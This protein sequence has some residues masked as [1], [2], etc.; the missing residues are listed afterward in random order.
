MPVIT[1][2]EVLIVLG[3]L[4]WTIHSFLKVAGGP[5]GAKAFDNYIANFFTSIL[6]I[7]VALLGNVEN[8]LLP[9]VQAF[10][11]SV[12]TLGP[13]MNATMKAPAAAL[14]DAILSTAAHSLEGKTNIKP[15]DWNAIAGDAMA[16]AVGFGLG[17]FATSAAF[18]AAFPEKL[19]T[20]NSLGPMLATLSGFEEVSRAAIRPVLINGIAVP[21]GYDS[22]SK[23]R[24]HLPALGATLALWARRKITNAE[25]DTLLAYNGMSPDWVAALQAGAYRPLQP[26]MLVNLLRD[27]PIDRATL[28]AMLEDAALSPA[29]VQLLA[30]KIIYNSDANVR[31]SLL[32]AL[33]T[34]YG[35]GVTSD[36]ELNDA[37]TQFNFSSEAKQYVTAHVLILRREVLAA[38]AEKT[39]VPLVANGNVSADE[40]LQQLEAAGVQPW[41]AELQITLATTRATIHAAKLEAAAERKLTLARQR[42]ATRAAVAEF[43]VGTL[44]AA[45]LTAALLLAGLD[46]VLAASV[47][48]VEEAKRAGRLRVVYGQ[49]LSPADA[50]L[51]TEKV[52]AIEQQTKDQLITLGQA[53][54]QLT[55]LNIDAPEIEALIARWAATLKK[56]PGA[57]VLLPP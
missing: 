2:G 16:D 31:N 30:D 9:I 39:V 14:A 44:D 24:S 32:S 50:K 8:Q 26:R 11:N 49:L 4:V 47:V 13:S 15:S 48:A 1:L 55:G 54:A 7:A 45:A 46:P 42:E 51:L 17:S 43:E 53:A 10:T 18:E 37:L 34:G 40:G 21:A 25:R 57:A 36:Q 19:N 52:A 41:Y 29:N 12:Q 23:F 5:K 6:G 33:I 38:E 27:Q 20:L 28:V 22:N 35:K 3:L 56:S